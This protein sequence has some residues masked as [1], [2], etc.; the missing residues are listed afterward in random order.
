L[1]LSVENGS[2]EWDVIAAQTQVAIQSFLYVQRFVDLPPAAANIRRMQ[3]EMVRQAELGSH[4]YGKEPNRRVRI[5]R[6]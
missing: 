5:Y 6:E 3:H 1:I 4:S 2:V